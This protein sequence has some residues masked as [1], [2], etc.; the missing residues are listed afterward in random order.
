[1]LFAVQGPA[2]SQVPRPAVHPRRAFIMRVSPLNLVLMHM[3]FN[4]AFKIFFWLK[5][6]DILQNM[7]YFMVTH[8][9]L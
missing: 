4:R 5:T 3:Y 8:C 2:S 9:I 7:Q 1:V 6:L